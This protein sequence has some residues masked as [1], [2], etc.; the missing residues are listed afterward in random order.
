MKNRKLKILAASDIH[1]DSDLV[2]TL[3]NK[4]KKEKADAVVLCGDITGGVETPNII[5]P[6]KDNNL[7]VF[8]VPGNHDEIA[9]IDFLSNIYEIKNM[10]SSSF[11]LKDVGFFGTG[12]AEP[13]P[14]TKITEE[15]IFHSLNNS[16]RYIKHKKK[17][18]MITHQ[19][20]SESKSEFSGFEGSKGLT[21]A[22][23]RFKPDILIHGHIHEAAGMEDQIGPTKIFNVGRKGRI[24]EI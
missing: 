18:V 11:E 5:K 10:H 8:I 23:K 19:H 7:E 22:I 2:K 13:S 1:G 17:K 21:K 4:A 12:Y 6:F 3:A 15:K 16:H 9:T 20:P 14:L 24:I